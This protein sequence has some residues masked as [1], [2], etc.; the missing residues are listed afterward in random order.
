MS[1]TSLSQVYSPMSGNPN[2]DDLI[3]TNQVSYNYELPAPT[4][5]NYS[6]DSSA[7]VA[8]PGNIGVSTMDPGQEAGVIDM[9]SYVSSLTGIT[10]T[11]TTGNSS[12]PVNLFFGYSG[13]FNNGWYGVD[14]NTVTYG[15]DANNNIVSLNIQDSILL[16]SNYDS[17]GSTIPGSVGY[18]A[19]LHEIGHALG[20]KNAEDGPN[21]LPANLDSPDVTIMTDAVTLDP[22]TQQ[23][24]AQ[25]G[26]LDIAALNW[27]YGG[28]GLLGTYGLTVNSSGV[29][30]AGGFNPAQPGQT[31]ATGT[32]G[33]TLAALTT[34]AA[35]ATPVTA[36]TTA[37]LSVT[38][39]QQGQLFALS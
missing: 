20:L 37:G 19:L 9:L 24:Y 36:A 6:F 17:V 29:P 26:S 28:D 18:D 22:G 23:T 2:I 3:W 7:A 21:V 25:F 10:F 31:T 38:P 30:I 13:D 35:T 27:L 32:A 5:I 1:W 4:T 33:T 14:Y 12:A 8:V 16:N 11:N 34:T 39:N 15:Q